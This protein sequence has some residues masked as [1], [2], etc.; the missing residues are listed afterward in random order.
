MLMP[1]VVAALSMLIVSLSLS[2]SAMPRF[3]PAPGRRAR[4]L[5]VDILRF[6]LFVSL[7]P[8]VARRMDYRAIGNLVSLERAASAKNQSAGSGRWNSLDIYQDFP[9]QC[10]GFL[11]LKIRESDLLCP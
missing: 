2:K 11:V 10:G 4:E 6:S 3:F 9:F 1:I 8:A 5:P 7:P